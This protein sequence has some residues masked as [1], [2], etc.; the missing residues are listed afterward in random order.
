MITIH[1]EAVLNESNKTMIDKMMPLLNVYQCRTFLGL[2]C[3][4]LGYGIIT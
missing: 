1:R 3:E 4:K 2:Y